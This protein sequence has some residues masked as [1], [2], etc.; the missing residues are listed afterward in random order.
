MGWAALSYSSVRDGPLEKLRGERRGILKLRRFV[1]EGSV[2]EA[3]LFKK[4]NGPPPPDIIQ[5]S[6]TAKEGR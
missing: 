3:K 4:F 1:K 2:N 6:P 5:I